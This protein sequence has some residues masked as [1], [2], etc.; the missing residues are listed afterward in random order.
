MSNESNLRIS[1]LLAIRRSHRQF[2]G[3][4]LS[5]ARVEALLE[6]AIQAPN[7]KRNEPWRFS[8]VAGDDISACIRKLG[9]LAPQVYKDSGVDQPE[10][11]WQKLATTLQTVGAIVLVSSLRDPAPVRDWENYAAVACAI[12]NLLLLAVDQGLG[13]FWSTNRLFS[14]DRVLALFGI[15]PSRERFAAALWLGEPVDRPVAPGFTLAGK[16]RFWS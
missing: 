5:R 7:H 15:D 9:A 1:D 13:S 12:E 8:V 6:K 4:R 11:K 10:Q 14:D 2:S 16:V 3:Q